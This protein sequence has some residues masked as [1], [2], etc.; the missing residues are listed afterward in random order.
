MSRRELERTNQETAGP[1]PR[2]RGRALLVSTLLLILGGVAYGGIFS[3]NKFAA[4]VSFPVFAY[5]F[6]IALFA[7]SA[8]LAIGAITGN[9][10]KI[11]RAHLWQY[12]RLAILALIL[13]VVTTAFAARELPAGVIT[14]VLT[15]V[16][17]LTFLMSFA[18]RFERLLCGERRRH[19][20]YSRSCV[21]WSREWTM[22]VMVPF[23][24]NKRT[25]WIVRIF[26]KAFGFGCNYTLS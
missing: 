10:P 16:P 20:C 4:S 19:Y 2:L 8:L 21:R 17:G 24:L 3:A 13:P 15:L 11:S 9:L 6:W 26:V 7:G 18:A 5:T 23:P 22:T 25:T 14:L 12:A 1:T